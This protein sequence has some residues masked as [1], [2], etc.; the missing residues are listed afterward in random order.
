MAT[1]IAVDT[2]DYQRGI[3]NAQKLLSTGN[4]GT[5]TVTVG[6]PPNCETLIVV[7][8]NPAATDSAA[9]VG[10]TSGYSYPGIQSL[11]NKAF[12]STRT[13][14]FDVT[15]TIDTQ[16][17][18]DVVASLGGAW[19]VYADAGV[20]IVGDVSRYTN[21]DGSQ[22]VIPTVPNTAAGDH[23]PNEMSVASLNSAASVT[24]VPAPGAGNRLRV[25][26]LGLAGV[27]GLAGVMR[28]NGSGLILLACQGACCPVVTF[29]AQGIPL[30][31]NQ[32]LSYFLVAGTGT[33]LGQATYTTETV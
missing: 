31:T 17:H 22:Y 33:M 29:P 3:V 23:P 1:P 18:I 5:G 6:V 24:V 28:D 13:W 9:V 30:S 10:V 4:A 25:F 21:H 8:E 19:S 32:A 15:N 2:P 11:N 27:A 20:H 26:S 16:C 14:F 12:Q 7:L